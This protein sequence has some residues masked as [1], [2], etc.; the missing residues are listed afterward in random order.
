[1]IRK[2][3]AV[4]DRQIGA[5]ELGVLAEVF[6][7]DRTDDGLPGFDFAVCA[8]RRCLHLLRAEHGSAVANAF[9]RRMV[10]AAHRS[11]GQA[12]FVEAAVPDPGDHDLASLVA[13]VQ[14]HLAEPVTVDDLAARALMS[15]RTFAR[16]F[17][18]ATGTTPHQWLL[19]QRMLL[20]ERLLEQTD[21]PVDEIARRCGLGSAD[22]LRHHFARRRRVSPVGYRRAF[23]AGVAGA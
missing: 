9:A 20:A 19:D 6:G 12:Q 16:R 4:V 22:T 17:R 7:L 3:T 13:W 2:V 11:G 5:F 14:E 18:A 10:V 21:L 8:A 1:V 15:A 23:R